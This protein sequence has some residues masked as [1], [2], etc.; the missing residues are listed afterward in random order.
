MS[1]SL[2]LDLEVD[3]V[4]PL[5]FCS[6]VLVVDVVCCPLLFFLEEVESLPP[7]LFSFLVLSHLYSFTPLNDNENSTDAA[8]RKKK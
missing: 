3:L 8:F 2:G 6:S 5:P 7:F 1:L 4:S